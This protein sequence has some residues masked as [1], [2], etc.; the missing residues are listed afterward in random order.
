M[1]RLSSLTSFFSGSS[2]AVDQPSTS[3]AAVPAIVGHVTNGSSSDDDEMDQSA[4]RRSSGGG[5]FPDFLH[6]DFCDLKSATMFQLVQRISKCF[7]E[8]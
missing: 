1:S 6:V 5:L 7:G 8:D 3:T 4:S 2:A